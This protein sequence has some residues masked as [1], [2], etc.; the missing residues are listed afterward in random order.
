M[1]YILGCAADAILVLFWKVT[2]S[3]FLFDFNHSGIIGFD[4]AVGH[5]GD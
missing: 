5:D 4:S 1:L 2:Q 3:W